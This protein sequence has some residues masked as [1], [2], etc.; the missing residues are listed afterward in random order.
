MTDLVQRHLAVPTGKTS[1]QTDVVVSVILHF[2]LGVGRLRHGAPNG[3]PPTQ[4]AVIVVAE[5]QMTL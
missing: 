4:E 5:F 1:V 3:L 2:T